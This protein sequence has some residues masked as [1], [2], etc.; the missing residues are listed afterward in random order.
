MMIHNITMP[1]QD[2]EF[3]SHMSWSFCVQLFKVRHGWSCCCIGKNVDYHCL[4]FLFK[5][6]IS[7]TGYEFPYFFLL[8]VLY[9]EGSFVFVTSL[10]LFFIK[11]DPTKFGWWFSPGTDCIELGIMCP[12]GAIS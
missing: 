7:V 8:L 4:S 3:Q 9:Q 6:N 10:N 12:S 11:M 1:N 2:L 5:I